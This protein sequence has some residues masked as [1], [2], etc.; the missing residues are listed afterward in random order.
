IEFFTVGFSPSQ[1]ISVRPGWMRHLMA[2]QRETIKVAMEVRQPTG[3]M[4]PPKI[5]MSTLL[6]TV[7]ALVDSVDRD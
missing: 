6:S 7:S 4:A 1:S 5:V 3:T 2:K